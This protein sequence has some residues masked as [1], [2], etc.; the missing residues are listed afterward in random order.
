L[1]LIKAVAVAAAVVAKPCCS[2]WYESHTLLLINHVIATDL[3]QSYC[4]KPDTR[5][6]RFGSIAGGQL[7]P[8]RVAL[9]L[10]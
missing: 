5:Y 10:K 2:A 1:T 4:S 6:F 3:W 9:N 7:D 8:F